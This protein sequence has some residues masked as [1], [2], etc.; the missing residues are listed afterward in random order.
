MIPKPKHNRIT[1]KIARL[2]VIKK[3]E[4]FKNRM[5]AMLHE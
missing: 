1:N 5:S 2:K 4:A 3:K